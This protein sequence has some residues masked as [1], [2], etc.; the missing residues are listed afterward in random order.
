MTDAYGEEHERWYCP[1]DD[2]DCCDPMSPFCAMCL[3][4]WP[5]ETARNEGAT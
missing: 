1:S 3:Q 4:D 2:M 5:C